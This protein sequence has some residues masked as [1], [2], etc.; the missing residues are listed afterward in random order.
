M[1]MTVGR[2]HGVVVTA[3]GCPG[4]ASTLPCCRCHRPTGGGGLRSEGGYTAG[5]QRGDQGIAAVVTRAL[6]QWA[7]IPTRGARVGAALAASDREEGHR[8]RMPV[9][10]GAI[11]DREGGE[12][13]TAT[14]GGWS[15][16]VEED[17]VRRQGRCRWWGCVGGERPW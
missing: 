6:A 16:E 12:G 8:R 9:H 1:T 5:R 14:G 17:K 11:G 10:D 4:R 15:L 7:R 2:L 13:A 3:L